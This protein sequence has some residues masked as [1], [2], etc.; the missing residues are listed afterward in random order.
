MARERG[1]ENR[2]RRLHQEM[3]KQRERARA[4]WKGAEKGV[5]RSGLSGAGPEGPDAGFWVM[6]SFAPPARDRA[7]GEAATGGE[8]RGRRPKPNWCWIRR[9]SMRRQADRLEIAGRCC[10]AESGEMVAIVES[11]YPAV[12]G[13][14]VHRIERSRRF[15]LGEELMAEVAERGTPGDRAQP[16]RD[17]PVA[18]GAAAGAGT[19]VKQAGSVVEPPRLRFDF[20]HYTAM[21]AGGNCGG[22]AARQRTHSQEHPVTTD[23]MPLE[24]RSRRARWLCS[25]KNTA[26]RYA[27]CRFRISARNCAA[28][29]T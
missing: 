19:Q 3:R 5:D 27:S 16:Y 11:A 25:A 6:R 21:D 14:T 9:H 2:S 13:L 29:R 1:L 8:H 26:T 24:R 12:P 20:T 22:G 17:A 15:I 18:C 28:A 4:S 23:V 10:R 7:V